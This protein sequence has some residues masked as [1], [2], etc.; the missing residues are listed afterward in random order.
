MIGVCNSLTKAWST[1]PK[2]DFRLNAEFGDENC[3]TRH[4]RIKLTNREIASEEVQVL[5][6]DTV[7]LIEYI[8]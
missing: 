4:E 7:Y 8:A 5:G 1:N 3:E 6:K 2:C